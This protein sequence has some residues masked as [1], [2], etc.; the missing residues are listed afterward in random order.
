MSLNMMKYKYYDTPEGQDILMKSIVTS[1]Y[2][3][4]SG[5]GAATFDVLMYSQPKGIVATAGRFM[6][7]IGP[8]VG[9]A[10]AFTVT[11]NV[12]QNIRGKNDKIN[13]FLGGVAAGSVFGAWQRSITISVP[14]AVLLGLVA[15]VKKTAIDEGWELLPQVPHAT[16]TIQSVKRDW[17]IVKD[18]EELKNYTTESK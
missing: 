3:A 11:T 5:L 12:A 9:M 10:T 6:W 16:K 4:L 8:L 7:Y 14:M 15:V 18:I 13:Y 17:S 2:A 1:K